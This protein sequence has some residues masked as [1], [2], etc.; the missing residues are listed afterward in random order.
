MLLLSLI[1]LAQASVQDAFVGLNNALLRDRMV[2][3]EDKKTL[4]TG[5]IQ[6]TH[7]IK[8]ASSEDIKKNLDELKT[9]AEMMY[10]IIAVFNHY[11]IM[12]RV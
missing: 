6:C 7:K 11:Y 3:D 9:V 2:P 1:V 5:L 12:Y 8:V 10:K 4:V